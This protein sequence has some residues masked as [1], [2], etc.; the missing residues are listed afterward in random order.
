MYEKIKMPHL[1]EAFLTAMLSF[2]YFIASIFACTS[3]SVP[4]NS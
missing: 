1:C 3:A 2:Y 4:S